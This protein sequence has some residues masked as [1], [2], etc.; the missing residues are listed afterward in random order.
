MMQKNTQWKEELVLITSILDKT[1]L[2][3]TIKWGTEVFTYKG[4]NV[5]SFGGF[6]NFF[7]IWFYNGVF[8]N[9]KYN[10]LVNAQEGKTKSLRQWRFTSKN[11]MDE[12]KIL[13]YIAEAIEVEK[14]GLKIKPVKFTPVPVPQLLENELKKDKGLKTAFEKFTP[15]KQKEYSIYINEAKQEATKHKRIEKIKPMIMQGIGLNDKYQ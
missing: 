12:R 8:L 7:S 4:N 15:G 3:K 5:V 2:E 11:E 6:N 13:E 1:P 14:K 10:V 9:D